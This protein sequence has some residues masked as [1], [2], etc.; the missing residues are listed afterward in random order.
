M[1]KRQRYREKNKTY[2]KRKKKTAKAL[3]HKLTDKQIDL[4]TDTQADVSQ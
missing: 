4:N 1:A 2:E 3:E